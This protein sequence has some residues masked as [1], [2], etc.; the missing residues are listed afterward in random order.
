MPLGFAFAL[1][2]S[3]FSSLSFFFFSSFFSSFLR[4]RL[5]SS[6]SVLGIGLK[7]PSRRACWLLFRFFCSRA[8]PDLTRSS[9]KPFSST[10]NLIR[11]STSGASHLKSHSAWSAGRTSGLKKSSRASL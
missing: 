11:P 7:K 2:F 6:A 9:E 1:A 4:F 10:R 8:A 5:F 3:F